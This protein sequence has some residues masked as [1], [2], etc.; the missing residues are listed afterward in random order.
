MW[1]EKVFRNYGILPGNGGQLLHCLVYFVFTSCLGC[2]QVYKVLIKTEA[3]TWF[4]FRRYN[5]FHALQADV[6]FHE[7]CIYAVEYLFFC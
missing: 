5:E 4:V 7:H 6:S 3:Q 2:V 1:R